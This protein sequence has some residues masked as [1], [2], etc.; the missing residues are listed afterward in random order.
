MLT[1][2]PRTRELLR[3][4]APTS[5][6]TTFYGSRERGVKQRGFE[7]D[8]VIL[9]LHSLLG[10]MTSLF[11]PFNCHPLFISSSSSSSSRG[12]A[13]AHVN[14]SRIKPDPPNSIFHTPCRGPSRI[15]PSTTTPYS[16]VVLLFM[17]S[18]QPLLVPVA[19]D[20]VFFR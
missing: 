3:L 14:L 5:I 6:H 7:D 4:R 10:L 16:F 13:Q 15:S 20:V 19:P 12:E 9:Q 11:S 18:Y 1:I 8:T 2:C 17:R